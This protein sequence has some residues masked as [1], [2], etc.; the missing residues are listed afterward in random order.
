MMPKLAR[1]FA[2]MRQL[3]LETVSQIPDLTPFIHICA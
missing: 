1:V 2:N 3:L